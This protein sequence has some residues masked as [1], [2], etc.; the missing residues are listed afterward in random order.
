[1]RSALNRVLF[2]IVVAPLMGFGAVIVP[3]A[4]PEWNPVRI[5]FASIWVLFLLLAAFTVYDFRRFWWA[6]RLVAALLAFSYAGY[7]VH[8]FFFSDDPF[9]LFQSRGEASPRNALIGFVAVGLPCLWYALFG[10]TAWWRGRDGNARS[11]PDA[12]RERDG[13]T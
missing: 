2:W 3:L 10:H 12:E 6:T 5:A 1:M 9:V 7:L 8:E 11:I 4:I 13:R